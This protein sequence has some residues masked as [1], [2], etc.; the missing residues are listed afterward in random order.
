MNALRIG[1]VLG[2]V[3]ISKLSSQA[4]PYEPGSYA[5]AVGRAIIEREV[6]RYGQV[7]NPVWDRDIGAVV[8]RLEQTSGYP[9]LQVTYVV[10]GDSDFYAEAVIGHALVVKV[11][12]IR[13]LT[14]LASNTT[15]STQS[16]HVRFVAYLASVLA[17]ELA[18]ITLGH[19][20][21]LLS[22]ARR[23]AKAAGVPD[24]ALLNAS[25]YGE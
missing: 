16:Q 6:G 25:S 24:S 2:F 19:T 17:H 23:L 12:L 5:R 7:S 4:Q 20:D 1:P 18:H 3:L 15:S 9:G 8:N 14:A 13:S 22:R 21:S 11:G 10:V